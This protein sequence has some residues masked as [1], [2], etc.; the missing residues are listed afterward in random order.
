MTYAHRSA[1][2]LALIFGL[3]MLLT[4]CDVSTDEP[5]PTPTLPAA[6]LVPT[7]QTV[8]ATSTPEVTPVPTRSAALDALLAPGPTAP[9]PDGVFFQRDDQIWYLPGNEPA[10]LVV[11]GQRIGPW[12]QTVDGSRIALVRY[13]EE[14]GQGVEEIMLVNNDGSSGDPIYGPVSTTGT[15]ATIEDLDWSWDGQQLA[16]ILSNGTIATMRF[17]PADPFRTRPPLEPIQVPQ[18]VGTLTMLGWAP[19]GAG[20][21]YVLDAED[22]S[23]LFATP[24][25][26]DALPVISSDSGSSRHVRTF[27]WLPG[28]GRIAFVEEASGRAS[29]LSDSIFTIAPDGTSLELLVSSGQFAP[30]ASV[31]HLSA[32]PDGRTLAFT[33]H[34]PDARGQQAFQSLWILTID[35][36]EL[37]QVPVETGYRVVDLT[38]TASGLIWRGIDRNA[39]TPADGSAYATTEPFVLTRFDP[40]SGNTSVVFQSELAG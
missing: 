30:A 10:R 39:R 29:P 2:T 5:D 18:D 3:T 22:D 37:Q 15:V 8:D 21:A 38:W 36:G 9:A 23:T 32:G 13:R 31:M 6:P 33:V 17:D 26:D 14:A 40:A 20:I 7:E 12:A 28:R 16:A 35:S 11:D 25:G 4:A 19:G 34:A 1:L 27:D 24:I